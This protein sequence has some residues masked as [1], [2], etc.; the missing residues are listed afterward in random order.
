LKSLVFLGSLLL[1]VAI[2]WNYWPYS[3]LPENLIVER[4]I[5]E[6]G[7]RKMTVYSKG[8]SVRTYSISLGS[9]PTGAKE[10]EGDMKTPEGE[11]IIDSKNFNSRFF[12]NLGI[13]YP[14]STDL[15]N[16]KNIGRNPGGDIK[17]HGMQSKYAFIGKF[18]RLSD[19]TNGCIALTNVEIEDLF[20]HVPVGTPITI[21]P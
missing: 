18:Q 14:N 1:I 3:K 10:F 9:E 20:N 13:S 19:W 7:R 6:K 2:I 5:V 16:A 4:I 8:L 17:I 12:R 15:K 11:Y 21:K